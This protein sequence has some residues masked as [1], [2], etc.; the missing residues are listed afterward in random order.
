MLVLGIE[1]SCDEC[2]LALV[3]N[4]TEIR[5][6]VIASQ[7]EEHAEF[8]GVVPEIASRTHTRWILPLYRKL[9]QEAELESGDIDGV[10]VTTRPG[11]TGSLVVGASFGKGLA[12]VLGVPLVGIDHIRGHLYA[13]QLEERVAYPYLGAI[14][15]GGHTLI[16]RVDDYDTVTVLGATIDDACGEAFDKVAK[17]Y[18]FGYPGGVWIDRL[19][20]K[21]DPAAFSFPDVSLHKGE[22]RYDMSYSGLKTAVVNQLDQF[23]NAGYERTPENIAASFQKSAIDMVV[24]RLERAVSDTGIPRVV[25]GGGVAANSYFRTAVHALEGV[26]VH[27]PSQILCTDNAAMIAGLGYHYLLAG[28]TDSWD[29]NVSARVSGFRKAYPKR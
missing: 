18:G 21:G 13:I 29:L 6:Q 16:A 12:F 10:A 1:S 20:Q 11:L 14:V 5:H 22:H 25:L 2:A 4:G 28:R 17:H 26:E 9:L 8:N 19:S 24:R 15:S 3:E 23:H 27:K 7:I